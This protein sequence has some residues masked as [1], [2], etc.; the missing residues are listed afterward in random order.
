[1]RGIDHVRKAKETLAGG[2]PDARS[3]LASAA[4]DFWAALQAA[5]SWPGK[6]EPRVYRITGRLFSRAMIDRSV[7]R[8]EEPEVEETSGLLEAYCDQSLRTPVISDAV[9]PQ[10]RGLALRPVIQHRPT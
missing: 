1:M 6:F 5:D 2:D 4:H 10:R 7:A 8:M 3:R 9:D